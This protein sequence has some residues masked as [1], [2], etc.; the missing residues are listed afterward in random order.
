MEM[1]AGLGW[2]AV[3]AGLTHG[4]MLMACKLGWAGVMRHMVRMV[5]CKLGWAGVMGCI[6]RMAVCK[7]GEQG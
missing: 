7:L 6:V 1:Q 3:F 5:A 2:V 4:H